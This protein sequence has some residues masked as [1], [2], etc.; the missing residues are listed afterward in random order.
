MSIS[1]KLNRVATNGIS[2][3]RSV[4]MCLMFVFLGSILFIGSVLAQD[5]NS[6]RLKPKGLTLPNNEIY[7]ASIENEEVSGIAKPA[8][9]IFGGISKP[10]SLAARSIGS[11]AK[12][13]LAGAQSPKK[14]MAQHGKSCEFREIE[15]GD[16]LN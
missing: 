7:G 9:Q 15:I 6:P 12:G 5:F 16:I 1:K 13:C 3:F 11:Y 10:S 2:F 8:N 4:L 14:L